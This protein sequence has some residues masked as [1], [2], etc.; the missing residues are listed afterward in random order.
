MT[1]KKRQNR[2]P[3]VPKAHHQIPISQIRPLQ[4]KGPRYYLK[5]A[6]DYPIFGCWV[7]AQWEE[8]GIAPVV[9]ARKQSEDRVIFGL[10]L[11]DIWCLG[12]KDAFANADVSLNTFMKNLPKMCTYEPQE[13]SVE[14]AHELIYG[15][16]EFAERYG[17]Q[18]H[19]DFNHQMVDKVLDPPDLHPRAHNIEF[20][21]DGKPFYVHGP[22]DDKAKQMRIFSTLERTAGPGNFDYVIGEAQPPEILEFADEWDDD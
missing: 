12:I 2:K 6:R 13:C 5:N 14:F 10:C 9:I 11:V 17:F 7:Y 3:Q 16:M 15:A 4:L 18:P 21:K 8:S 20:G 19:K 22:Y 1:K